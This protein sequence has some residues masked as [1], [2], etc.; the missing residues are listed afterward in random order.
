MGS[1]VQW[2]PEFDFFVLG[3]V[4]I[5]TSSWIIL[6]SLVKPAEPQLATSHRDDLNRNAVSRSP[7]EGHD[8]YE[9]GFLLCVSA[10]ATMPVALKRETT[11]EGFASHQWQSHSLTFG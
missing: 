4:E 5:Q 11:N 9:P 8:G 1:V 3:Y 7:H 10:H 2:L 6:E